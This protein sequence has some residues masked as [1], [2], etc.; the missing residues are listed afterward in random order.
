[1]S[2]RGPWD[3]RTD[4]EIVEAVLDG[5][6]DQYAVLVGRYQTRLYRYAVGMMRQPDVAADVVQDSFIKAYSKLG[7][8]RDPEAFGSWLF[9]IL[10][11]G[12][13]DRLKSAHSQGVGLDEVTLIA[14]DQ[15]GPDHRLA[16]AELGRELT[17][18]LGTLP[19]A[20]R[21]AF[22]LKH[23]EGLSYDEMAE[24]MDASVSALKM[25]V[26]RA[27]EELQVALRNLAPGDVTREGHESS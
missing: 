22:L 7:R 14:P 26:K 19:E 9:R 12:V 16:N 2:A 11:N 21:E 23:V 5:R 6:R 4:A 17:A 24:R 1:M 13:L 15:E 18:A 8:C 10:R 3:D 25:R 20:Q 27:R